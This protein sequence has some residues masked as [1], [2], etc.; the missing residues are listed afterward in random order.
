[1][2]DC[3][4]R[5][6]LAHSLMFWLLAGLG[7]AAAVPCLVVPPIDAYRGLLAIEAGERAAVER[8][9]RRIDDQGQ[10]QK[11]LRSDPMVNFRLAQRELRYRQPGGV[12]YL[13]HL[14]PA[15]VDQARAQGHAEPEANLPAWMNRLY[16]HRWS[17]V[18]QSPVT[19][20]GVLF[21][22]LSLIVFALA[23]YG[24]RSVGPYPSG[25]SDRPWT[26]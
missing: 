25:T 8:L 6:P 22:S 2:S 13:P 3:S 4:P 7:F 5:E 21:L 18:Y 19:R 10:L 12:A 16:P 17:A 14:G 26:C 24:G 9:Q 11:A 1:M 23:T 20:R 15:R